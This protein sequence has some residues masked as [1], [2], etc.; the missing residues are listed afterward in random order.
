MPA[1]QHLCPHGM[2]P[3]SCPTCFS[4]NG[5]KPLKPGQRAA[6]STEQ[7]QARNARFV[8]PPEPPQPRTDNP[9]ARALNGGRD[10]PITVALKD[11]HREHHAPPQGDDELWQPPVHAKV[12][13]RMPS[14]PEAPQP[15]R[16]PAPAARP[17]VR[18]KTRP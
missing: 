4:Q 10:I 14:H 12:S 9:K 8:A 16:A 2:N 15:S 18:P 1:A 11:P 17:L 3:I 7:E 6:G 13:E 5:G